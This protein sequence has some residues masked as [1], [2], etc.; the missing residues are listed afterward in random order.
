MKLGRLL[1]IFA[2]LS[3]V[4][5]A[6]S[7]QTNVDSSAKVAVVYSDAFDDEKGGINRVVAAMNALNKEFGPKLN[8]L[9]AIDQ[10]LKQ[11][12]DEIVA[13][14]KQPGTQAQIAAKSD[15][16]TQLKTEGQRKT[17]DSQALY[18]KRKAAVL[19]PLQ[20]DISKALEAYA[21]S[22]GIVMI[23]DG[24]QVPLVFTAD[25]LDITRAFIADYNSK[26]PATAAVNTP[27]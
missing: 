7:A 1:L 24:S 17:E 26:N 13:L 18:D 5:T 27:R 12:Q 25:A 11:L 15:Q 21:K 23:F 10:K 20:E 3:G 4:A 19:Q 6:V 2:L 8:E 14:Q 22:H 9:K 16:F